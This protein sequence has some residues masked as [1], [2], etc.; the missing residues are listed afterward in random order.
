MSSDITEYP[1]NGCNLC[2]RGWNLT[3]RDKCLQ[4]F[5]QRGIRNASVVAKRLQSAT[6]HDGI[7]VGSCVLDS[8]GLCIAPT[9][10]IRNGLVEVRRLRMHQV[11]V[12]EIV[13]IVFV[14][15]R[16]IQEQIAARPAL[17]CIVCAGWPL[18]LLA[19]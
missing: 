17:C 1:K 4:S 10:Y 15:K 8:R 14:V 16:M 6:D 5:D 7:S 12:R 3:L 9:H 2:E 19:V 18:V 11:R 13:F